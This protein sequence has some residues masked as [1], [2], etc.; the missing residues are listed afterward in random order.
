MLTHV[1]VVNIILG[2]AH[3]RIKQTQA[4]EPYGLHG[5][6]VSMQYLCAKYAS[7]IPGITRTI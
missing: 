1:T 2:V 6:D 4:R 5:I 7:V 3:Q